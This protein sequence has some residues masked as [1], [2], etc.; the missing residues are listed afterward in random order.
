MKTLV[1][2]FP[3]DVDNSTTKKP[4]ALWKPKCYPTLYGIPPLK[5]NLSQ[6][7][8][9][10]N[11]TL[12]LS[13]SVFIL[14]FLRTYNSSGISSS[15]YCSYFLLPYKNN[16]SLAFKAFSFNFPRNMR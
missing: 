14:L 11:F 8:T 2:N 3:S 12:R 9:I 15:K 4:R 5:P 7:N 13:K 10:Y 6:F 16:V 1:P